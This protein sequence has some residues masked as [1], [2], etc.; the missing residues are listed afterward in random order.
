MQPIP[1]KLPKPRGRAADMLAIK[2]PVVHAIGPDDTVFDA[3]HKMSD[4]RVGALLV[5]EGPR[6]V[7]VVSERDYTRKVILLGR[8]SK[9][10]PVRDIMTPQ[11]ITIGPQTSLAE[12]LHIVNRHSIRHLPVVEGEQVL[13]VLSVGDLVR[14]VLAQ[15][16]ETIESLNAFIGSDYPN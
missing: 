11:V 3:I 16:A 1:E 13:G 15:Q 4:C 8:A 9:E 12:C 6:L 10:T 7:G 14:A 5:M 2:G